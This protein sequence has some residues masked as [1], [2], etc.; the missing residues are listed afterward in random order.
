MIEG[1]VPGGDYGIDVG[2]YRCFAIG[3]GFG[4]GRVRRVGQLCILLKLSSYKGLNI[5]GGM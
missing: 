5:C 4:L 2:V 1:S 3:D